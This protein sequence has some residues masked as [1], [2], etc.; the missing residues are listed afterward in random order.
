MQIKFDCDRIFLD[1]G[2]L[3]LKIIVYIK[4]INIP[5]HDLVFQIF[6]NKIKIANR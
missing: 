1:L 6:A 4:F 2:F 3:Y 5:A